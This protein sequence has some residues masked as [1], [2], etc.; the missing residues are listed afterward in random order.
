[1]IHLRP[2][3]DSD[4][5]LLFKFVN[6][7]DSLAW[8]IR[9]AALISWDEHTKWLELRLKNHNCRI[10]IIVLDNTAVGQI[11]L[12]KSDHTVEI[13]IYVAQ[14]FRKQNIASQALS[15]AVKCSQSRWRGLPL[16]ALVKP[17]NNASIKLFEKAGFLVKNRT[18]EALRL[19]LPEEK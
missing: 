17:N 6:E 16:S 15:F 4:A 3:V 18:I 8:K 9:T 14:Q 5:S 13:D 19:E 10:W 12:E 1:M 2:A 11:R 7:P